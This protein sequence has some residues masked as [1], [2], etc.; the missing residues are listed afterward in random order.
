MASLPPR[1]AAAAAAAGPSR[2]SSS[3]ERESTPSPGA[4]EL[5]QNDNA[6]P[7]EHVFPTRP[8]TS[9]SAPPSTSATAAENT[10]EES[11][12]PTVP[13]DSEPRK[14]WIC[15]ADETEDTPLNGEWRS[16]C[17]CNLVAHESCLL[18]WLA[19]MENPKSPRRTGTTAKMSCPQCKSEIH[20]ARPRSL[21]VDVVQTLERMVGKLVLPGVAF[22]LAGTVW[23]GCC[24]HGVSS[25]YVVFGREE[26]GRILESGSQ[27]A[28]NPRLNLGV[29]L[30]P[31]VLVFSRT[32]FAEGLLPA[33]PVLFFATHQPGR[34]ELEL[35]MWPPSAAVTFAALPYAKSFY[36]LFYEKAFGKLERK[37]LAEVQPRA[38]E[39]AQQDGEG[40][41]ADNDDADGDADGEV[42]M[43]IELQVGM[44]NLQDHLRGGIQAGG[45]Q[46]H[47]GAAAGEGGQAG[48]QQQAEDAAG[49]Q[50]L[51][52]RQDNIIHESSSIADTVLGALLFPA[53]S[54]SVGGI[55]KMALPKTWTNPASSFDKAKAGLLQTKWGRSVVGGCL[56]VLIKDALVLY[57]RWKLAQSHRKRRV[58]NYDRKKK[59]IVN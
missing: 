8:S 46:H 13:S 35:D 27:R 1:S 48:D 22:T 34:H 49:N 56:F 42:L 59:K 17:P 29:P 18:D 16:P 10:K 2:Q 26:L 31:L 15:Y 6:Y 24:A 14:C 19:D 44:G 40:E 25:M 11:T 43:E 30:I 57:C 32:R 4:D 36:N 23:A 41:G 51:G 21:V 9:P 5:A 52:R 20:I 55:L 28:W 50:I 3:R 54:A 33:I 53:I 39:D 38:D 45:H 37:W 7:H 58:L 47:G 12:A